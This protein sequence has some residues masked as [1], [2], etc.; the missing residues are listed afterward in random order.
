M[1]VVSPTDIGFLTSG[2]IVLAPVANGPIW[3]PFFHAKPAIFEA[4]TNGVQVSQKH[5]WP[6]RKAEA[7][8]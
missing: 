4:L 7:I 8:Y 3:R 1:C 2:R 6:G 5:K